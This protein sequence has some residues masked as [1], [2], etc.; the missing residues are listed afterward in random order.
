MKRLRKQRQEKQR[1]LSWAICT[2][3]PSPAW[4]SQSISSPNP[5]GPCHTLPALSCS[6][7]SDFI[8]FQTM[9]ITIPLISRHCWRVIQGVGFAR[10]TQQLCSCV[11]S[12]SAAPTPQGRHPGHEYIQDIWINENISS[13]EP[14]V[15]QALLKSTEIKYPAVLKELLQTCS[16][17]DPKLLL[18]RS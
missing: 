5:L 13:L 7:S 1:V 8:C 16:L 2:A 10:K 9:W 4:V 18:S 11:C 17:L 14:N 15:N 12:C 3:D 6:S